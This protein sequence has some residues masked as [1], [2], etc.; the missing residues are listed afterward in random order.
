MLWQ[1]AGRII[2]QG[3]SVTMDR[4]IARVSQLYSAKNGSHIV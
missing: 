1:I 2:A 3:A 4:P